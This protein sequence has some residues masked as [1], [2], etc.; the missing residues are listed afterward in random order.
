MK[1]VLSLCAV[2]AFGAVLGFTVGCDT[3]A[4]NSDKVKEGLEGAGDKAKEL[5]SDFKEQMGKWTDDTKDIDEKIAAWGED[6][7][8]DADEAKKKALE[9]LK[10][11]RKAFA[12]SMEDAKEATKDGAKDALE[13]TKEKTSKAWDE[14]KEAY[15]AAKEK[16]TDGE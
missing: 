7:G 16:L 3:A 5:A 8:D 13:A 1:N 11:K 9:T 15:E 14:L 2:L 6:L 4:T 10:E 12:E